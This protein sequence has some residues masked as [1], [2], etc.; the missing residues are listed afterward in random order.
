MFHCISEMMSKKY[1]LDK[2]YPYAKK[3]STN[4]LKKGLIDYIL[5]EIY[6][7][8]YC[9]TI[10]N[11]DE[12]NTLVSYIK[13]LYESNRRTIDIYKDFIDTDYDKFYFTPFF[14]E[15]S[16]T[17]RIIKTKSLLVAGKIKDICY[18]YSLR[19]GFDVEKLF[20]FM[21]N[22]NNNPSPDVLNSLTGNCSTEINLGQEN[23]LDNQSSSDE[24]VDF[25]EQIIS[26]ENTTDK[27]LFDDNIRIII[28]PIYPG[29]RKELV[30]GDYVDLYKYRKV[31]KIPINYFKF[32]RKFLIQKRPFYNKLPFDFSVTRKLFNNYYIDEN[33]D[34]I[35]ITGLNMKTAYRIMYIDSI[36]YNLGLPHLN[37]SVVSVEE[38]GEIKN[39]VLLD[40]FFNENSYCKIHGKKYFTVDDKLF[41]KLKNFVDGD[42]I[43]KNIIPEI[44]YYGLDLDSFN[45]RE[46]ENIISTFIQE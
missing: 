17:E 13:P 30:P 2:I 46:L 23:E 31:N 28:V 18:Y 33:I 8:N 19:F 26:T 24:L 38:F 34:R 21:S 20:D 14:D 16:K 43:D 39:Y 15:D 5:N 22:S 42:Y 45:E 3:A 40:N 36:L 4:Q 25:D 7:L 37:S 12:K 6:D 32:P 11:C 10:F 29:K 1:S 41:Q 44:L 35:I 9:K 27:I